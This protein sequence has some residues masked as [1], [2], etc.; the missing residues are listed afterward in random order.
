MGESGGRECG[1]GRQWLAAI[2]LML[3]LGLVRPAPAAAQGV[4]TLAFEPAEA[5]VGVGEETTVA[6][7]VQGAANLY[8]IELQ[9]Y[10]DASLLEV[11]DD[12]PGMPGIQVTYPGTFLRPDRVESNEADNQRGSL[13]LAFGQDVSVAAATG[14]GV[15]ATIR[16]RGLADG[17]SYLRVGS[18]VLYN[19][20]NG[21]MPVGTRGGAVYVGQAA[22]QEPSPTPTETAS[23][24]PT[25]VI[26]PTA[27]ETPTPTITPVPVEPEQPPT[28]T[29]AP[30]SAVTA[31]TIAEGIAPEPVAT[32]EGT[33]TES[34]LPRPSHEAAVAPVTESPVDT[35]TPAA[36]PAEPTPTRTPVK[37]A[38]AEDV[39]PEPTEAPAR[40]DGAAEPVQTS[41]LASLWFI[42]AVVGVL[43]FGFGVFVVLP[44]GRRGKA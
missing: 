18:A 27:T 41:P 25:V 40:V 26:E 9:L 17:Q 38:M 24:T 21:R 28:P 5:Y 6:V 11:L 35:P 29:P 4:T 42:A 2:A 16:V 39:T 44:R 43:I 30:E 7:V 10:F 34:P 13:V 20:D 23:P 15:L 33:W 36:E 3:V 19:A 1:L 12:D 37:Q 31:E 14:D 32:E 8:G 22:P